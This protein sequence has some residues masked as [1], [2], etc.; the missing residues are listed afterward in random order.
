MTVRVHAWPE[1]WYRFVSGRF[2][3]GSRSQAAASPWSGR[4][5]VFGPHVQLWQASFTT[6][7]MKEAVHAA[8]SSFFD[9]V[10]G[11]GGLIR[12]GHHL[13]RIPL[14]DVGV[15][16]GSEMFSDGTGFTDGT[17]FAT[18]VLPAIIQAASAA[19]QGTN[20]LIVEG[21]P[22]SEA[23]VLRKGDLFE[24]R[25]DGIADHIPSLHRVARSAPTDAEGRAGLQFYPSLRKGV[26][27]GD[28]IILK[29]PTGVFRLVDDEQGKIELSF[30]NFGSVGFTL[31]EAIQ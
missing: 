25:R 10:G 5:A 28:S 12:I 18:G 6:I 3:L 31:I 27:A 20:E 30:P 29:N 11:R 13:R 24:I 2:E 7:D 23:N 26:A 15:T 19:A 21:L 4:S 16:P 17:G 8:M 22:A 9:E 1:E 14:R